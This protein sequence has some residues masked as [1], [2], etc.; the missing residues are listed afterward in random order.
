[1]YLVP[2]EYI[3]TYVRYVV[4]KAASM[5]MRVFCDI[6]PCSLVGIDRCFRGVYC[7]HHQGDIRMVIHHP[8]DGG[9]THL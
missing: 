1:M 6:A 9:S 4:L 8:D 3:K 2:A 7:L 5:K